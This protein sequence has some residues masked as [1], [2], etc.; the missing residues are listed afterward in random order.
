MKFLETRSTEP[1]ELDSRAQKGRQNDLSNS[2]VSHEWL[3]ADHCTDERQAIG[4]V[5]DQ[6]SFHADG[7]RGYDDETCPFV[8]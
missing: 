2:V 6:R 1:F 5:S 4:E 8:T 3:L 7:R